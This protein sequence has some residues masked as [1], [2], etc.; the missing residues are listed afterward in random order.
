MGSGNN[1]SSRSFAPGS[2]TLRCPSSFNFACSGVSRV[3]RG[4][5]YT[6]AGTARVARSRERPRDIQC[7]NSRAYSSEYQ[8]SCLRGSFL[9]R[10]LNCKRVP[11]CLLNFTSTPQVGLSPIC[12]VTREPC[13]SVY[14]L[15][16]V[17]KSERIWNCIPIPVSSEQVQG[18]CRAASEL[19]SVTPLQIA[20]RGYISLNC[21]PPLQSVGLRPVS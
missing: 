13:M 16:V 9:R 19:S 15:K 3:S 2:P 20:E 18:A 14:Y 7:R 5:W 21:D 6:V 17:T 11:F 1:K 12:I 4:G 10:S 8:R